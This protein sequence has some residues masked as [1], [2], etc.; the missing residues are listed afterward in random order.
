[1]SITNPNTG[2][3]CTWYDTID[4][5]LH[6]SPV[7]MIAKEYKK[8]GCHFNEVMAHEREHVEVDRQVVNEYAQK[9]GVQLLQIVNAKPIT[10]PFP[11]A[12]KDRVRAQME[13]RLQATVA[14]NNKA[15]MADRSQRQAQIDS[16]ENYDAISERIHGVCDKRSPMTAKRVRRKL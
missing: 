11:T 9:L 12:Q 4:V 6:M 10:G 2:Q 5:N 15:M 1:M 3:T 7:I 14:A 8:G 13:K 16:K